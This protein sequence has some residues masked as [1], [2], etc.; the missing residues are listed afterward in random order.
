[1]YSIV[2]PHDS[3]RRS[4]SDTGESRPRPIEAARI[5]VFLRFSGTRLRTRIPA[6]A[7]VPNMMSVAPPSAAAGN[8]CHQR[9][10]RRHQA[11]YHQ[12]HADEHADMAAGDP[13]KL[14][15]AIVLGKDRARERLSTAPTT[16]LQRILQIRAEG[17]PTQSCER[18]NAVH[19]VNDIA[20]CAGIVAPLQRALPLPG[21]SPSRATAHRMRG[22]P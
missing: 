1:M 18:W 8:A 16:E 21:S 9:P 17:P 12:Y 4:A 13:G 22:V 20:R 15:D 7:T 3:A 14:N 19:P 11:Q 5:V 2:H 6:A 10:Y